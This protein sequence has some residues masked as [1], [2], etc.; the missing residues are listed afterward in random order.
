MLNAYHQSYRKRWIIMRIV[1]YFNRCLHCGMLLIAIAGSVFVLALL[2]APRVRCLELIV[3]PLP[4]QHHA[5]DAWSWCQQL[6]KGNLNLMV[7]GDEI[8]WYLHDTLVTSSRIGFPESEAILV[9]PLQALFHVQL[10]EFVAQY[11][12]QF[13]EAAIRFLFL[14]DA[15]YGDLVSMFDLLK[16]L[17]VPKYAFSKILNSERAAVRRYRGF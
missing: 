2:P 10:P 9:P 12:S 1:A 11:N 6:T 7:G 17:N 8:Y 16:N 15:K 5:D 4:I 13:P 3:A 14:P